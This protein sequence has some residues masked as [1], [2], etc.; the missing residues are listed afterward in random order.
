MD[1]HLNQLFLEYPYPN[2]L[3][4]LIFDA[5]I[6]FETRTWASNKAGP[7]TYKMADI[8]ALEIA[9]FSKENGYH[10]KNYLYIADCDSFESQI[11]LL[12]AIK[13]GLTLVDA[14]VHSPFAGQ[15]FISY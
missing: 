12:G 1:R 10:Q 15:S 14:S 13:A 3:G 7:L 4:R 2:T 6:S 11:V 8:S 5:A 9:A